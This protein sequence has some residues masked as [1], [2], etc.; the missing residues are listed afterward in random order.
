MFVN[1]IK[2]ELE[3]IEI[4]K[5]LAGR[6]KV[7]VKKAKKEQKS[8]IKRPFVAAAIIAAL[9]VSIYVTPSG[10]AMFE[11][12]FQVTKFE[13]RKNIEEMSIGYGFT[14]SAGYEEKSFDS[15]NEIENMFNVQVPFPSLFL[16]EEEDKEFVEYHV[17][18]DEQGEFT[19][20][21]YF[22]GTPERNYSV[23]ATNFV[24][25]KPQFSAETT[26]GT[27][28]EKDLVINGVSAKLLGIKEIDGYVIYME[29]DNWKLIITCFDRGSS[30]E[31]L[32]DVREEEI[33]E[34]SESITW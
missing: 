5:E 28:I 20:L 16:T 6:S 21:L 7:G 8:R 10:Q 25:A 32:S 33:I 2:R 30:L 14:D 22:S 19:Q 3:K 1:N 12:L 4:P 11:G 27:G 24:D 23:H 29:K 31:G 34:I 18:T 17:S 15:L 26:D 13:K 9:S